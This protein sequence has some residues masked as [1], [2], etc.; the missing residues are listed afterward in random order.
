MAYSAEDRQ[1]VRNAYINSNLTLELIAVQAGISVPTVSRWK[2]D[3]ADR[4]DNWD[5]HRAAVLMAGGGIEDIS[6]M[7]LL[8]TLTEYQVTMEKIREN[9]DIPAPER[10]DML[11]RLGDSFSKCIAASKKVLP[12]T[13]ELAIAM[14]VLKML[15]ELISR[16]YPKHL[17]AYLEIMPALGDEVKKK[18]G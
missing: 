6:R 2:R 7:I 11:T 18:Y 15:G 14:E 17:H 13:N 8:G 4:G 16:Q 3:A 10:V 12:E 5:K 1:K 9:P